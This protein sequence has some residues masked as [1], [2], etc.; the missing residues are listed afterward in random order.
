MPNDILN[1]SDATPLSQGAQQIVYQHPDDPDQLL[2]V[3][4]KTKKSYRLRRPASRRF[5]ALRLWHLEISEYF[6]ALATLGRHFDRMP[7]IGG[8]CDTSLGPAIIVQ[9]IKGNDGQI[10]PTLAQLL[11]SPGIDQH[12][13]DILYADAQAMFD[14]IHAAGVEWKDVGLQN[15]VVEGGATPHLVIIDGMG[16]SPLIP[17][18]LMNERIYD[19]NHA[20]DRQRFLD[21]MMACAPVEAHQAA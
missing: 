11:K 9:K 12:L 14:E 10:A 20:K 21:Q 15:V 1:L 5:R 17:L 2:K 13:F 19:Y 8:F 16:K 7:R 4:R 6:A 3:R 18:A